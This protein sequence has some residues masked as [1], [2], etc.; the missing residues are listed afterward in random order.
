MPKKRK[1]TPASRQ[2]ASRHIYT[3]DWEI[4]GGDRIRRWPSTDDERTI[5][6]TQRSWVGLSP[7]A[8]HIDVRVEEEDNQF[9]SE[10][11]NAWVTIYGDTGA[12]G[13]RFE[14]DVMSREEAEAFEEA[15]LA[16]IQANKD[17]LYRVSRDWDD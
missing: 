6:V 15:C 13:Y 11:E 2:R 12:R 7:G 16:I 8:K 17:Q 14:G 4:L 10:S 1:S 3:G 5:K 9:W